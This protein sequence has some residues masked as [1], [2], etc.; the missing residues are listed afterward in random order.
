MLVVVGGQDPQDPLENV[1]GV[2]DVMPN[3]RVVVVR[4]AGHGAV[5]HGCA[6]DLANA[7]VLSGSADG[8]DTRCAARAPLAPFVVP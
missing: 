1:A 8:L 3:A 2:R 5:N 6:D 7:F 4:G